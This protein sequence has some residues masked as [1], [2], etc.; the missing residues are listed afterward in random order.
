MIGIKEEKMTDFL[1]R[2]CLTRGNRGLEARRQ[3]GRKKSSFAV[4]RP[5]QKQS[6]PRV[7]ARACARARAIT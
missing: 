4:F 2:A 6:F 7:R 5:R 3:R 1:N